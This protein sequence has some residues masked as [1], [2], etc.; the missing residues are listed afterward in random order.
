MV[1]WKTR[2]QHQTVSETASR[3]HWI[4][5]NPYR[6]RLS[7]ICRPYFDIIGEQYSQR[8]LTRDSDKLPALAGLARAVYPAIKS[9]YLAGLWLEHIHIGLAWQI[10]TMRSEQ[11]GSSYFKRL[12]NGCPSWSYAS[13]GLWAVWDPLSRSNVKESRDNVA[14][15]CSPI[16]VK[17]VDVQLCEPDPF[18]SVRAV[19]LT[20]S[21]TGSIPQVRH[22]DE[23]PHL[24]YL[25][26]RN[27]TEVGQA[28]LDQ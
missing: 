1:T 14:P 21:E 16:K 9:R 12:S 10:S 18:G 24:V 11:L 2:P 26:H 15:L 3:L 13:C 4:D 6:N 28:T 7:V 17:N 25:S 8:E 5:T 27:G 23:S 19:C 22:S 20:V